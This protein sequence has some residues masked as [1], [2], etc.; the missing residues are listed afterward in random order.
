MQALGKYLD[1][2]IEGGLVDAMW[3]YA[4]NSL[5]H[6]AIWMEKNE[7]L[8][9]EKKDRLEFPN[10]TWAAQDIRKCNVLLYAAKFSDSDLREKFIRRSEYFFHEGFKQL[11]SFKTKD[12]TRPLVLMMQNGM[13]HSFFQKNQAAVFEIFEKQKSFVSNKTIRSVPSIF[14]GIQS[15]SLKSEI[16]FLKWRLR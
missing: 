10:E 4:R 15:F 3:W 7:Y 5:I 2:K 12:L 6:Y 11:V 16:E 1:V 8:Y 13:M 14:A 9:L